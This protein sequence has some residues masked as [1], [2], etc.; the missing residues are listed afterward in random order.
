[1]PAQAALRFGEQAAAFVVA[2]RL[3]VHPGGRATWP[4]RSPFTGRPRRRRDARGQR[5]QH[6]DVPVGDLTSS[7][8]SPPPTV[9]VKVKNEQQ[10]LSRAARSVTARH[11]RL[12]QQAQPQPGRRDPLDAAHGLGEQASNSA[13]RNGCSAVGSVHACGAHAGSVPI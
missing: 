7:D 9:R 6:V 12:G 3:Q 4:L 13:T 2:Q 8:S 11:R 10:P 1:M 5:I